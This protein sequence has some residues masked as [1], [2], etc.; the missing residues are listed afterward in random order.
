MNIEDRVRRHAA[1][2]R[3]LPAPPIVTRWDWRS[4]AIRRTLLRHWPALTA[5]ALPGALAVVVVAATSLSG[6]PHLPNPFTPASPVVRVPQSPSGTAPIVG[7]TGEPTSTST[8]TSAIPGAGAGPT[9]TPSAPPHA[10]A[11]GVPATPE[12][13]G[14]PSA[15]AGVCSQPS[16][17]D[18]TTALPDGTRY[19]I[20]SSVPIRVTLHNHGTA[21]CRI[22]SDAV[23]ACPGPGARVLDASGVEVWSSK[24]KCVQGG[25]HGSVGVTGQDYGTLEPGQSMDLTFTW[26]AQACEPA[27]PN[28]GCSGPPAPTGTYATEG[29]LGGFTTT[30]E[31]DGNRIGFTEY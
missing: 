25:A 15:A 12:P 23:D 29:Y 6:G 27:T 20:M 1:A 28:A 7:P 2:Y 5:V 18:V 13:S 21:S 9:P 19:R 31:S 3:A 8:P 22:A 24:G 26:N 11:G 30:A 4:R 10:G 14:A 17:I 16:D